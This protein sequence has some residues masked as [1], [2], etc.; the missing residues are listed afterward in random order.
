M[1]KN[2]LEGKIP[3]SGRKNKFGEPT[4]TISFRCPLSKLQE[5]ELLINAKL[6]EY[7]H[8]KGQES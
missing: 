5:M 8:N 6:Q 7:E 1:R 3:N 4:K 2:K